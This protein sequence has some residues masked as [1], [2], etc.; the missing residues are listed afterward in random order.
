M[1]TQEKI[2]V[3]FTFE[4]RGL[5]A[6]E[7][8]TADGNYSCLAETVRDSLTITRALQNL[9]K[10]GYSQIIVR[11]PVTEEERLLIIPTIR[12]VTRKVS[13]RGKRENYGY[14]NSS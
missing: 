13:N 3:V 6:L 5:A 7:E 2:R 14:R 12:A 8:M 4:E 9:A 10:R 1:A 11:D